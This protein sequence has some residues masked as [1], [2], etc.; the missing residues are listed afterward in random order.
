MAGAYHS[1]RAAVVFLRKSHV[2]H[3]QCPALDQKDSA[4]SLQADQ[5]GSVQKMAGKFDVCVTGSALSALR[6][7]LERLGQGF[8]DCL[9]EKTRVFARVTPDQKEYVVRVLN[10]RWL[11]RGVWRMQRFSLNRQRSRDHDVR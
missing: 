7:D 8:M 2:S 9:V 5:E 1:T 4:F 6:R 11:L 3:E 10:D